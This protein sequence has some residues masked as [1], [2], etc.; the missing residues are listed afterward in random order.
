MNMNIS[1]GVY[2]QELTSPIFYE[3]FI[4]I[5]YDYTVPKLSALDITLRD[6]RGKCTTENFAPSYTCPVFFHYEKYLERFESEMV[7]RAW[8]KNVPNSNKPSIPK[9]GRDF[10]STIQQHFPGSITE[11]F[12]FEEYIKKLQQC[13]NGEVLITRNIKDYTFNI[14]QLFKSMNKNYE[15]EFSNSFLGAQ[16]SKLS[17][18]FYVNAVST[19]QN[20]MLVAYLLEKERWS[21]A[22]LSCNAHLIPNSLVKA[23]NLTDSLTQLKQ[24]LKAENLVGSIDIEETS[25]FYK[26]PITDCSYIENTGNFVVRVQI[27]VTKKGLAPALYKLESVPFIFDDDRGNT[28]VRQLCQIR[29]DPR[30]FIFDKAS[31]ILQASKCNPMMPMC[32]LEHF[33]SSDLVSPCVSAI[34]TGSMEGVKRYC[35][36]ECIPWRDV[37]DGLK[38]LPAFHQ[39]KGD[40]WMVT[41]HPLTGVDI[42]CQ[43]KQ[44]K[45]LEHPEIGALEITVPCGCYLAY[46]TDSYHPESDCKDDIEPIVKH[47]LP[48]H[49]IKD[50]KLAEVQKALSPTNN[51]LN[52]TFSLPEP[53]YVVSTLVGKSF[54]GFGAESSAHVSQQSNEDSS[55]GGGAGLTFFW[56]VF[57]IQSIGFLIMVAIAVF[58]YV[59]RRRKLNA[60]S[61]ERLVYNVYPSASNANLS[62][63]STSSD[64]YPYA[65]Q[66]QR[67]SVTENNLNIM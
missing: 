66:S 67:S 31:G 49:F 53:D 12:G 22:E 54:E 30:T 24:I 27:P 59:D 61:K 33:G 46:H 28:L 44:D 11:Q 38:L 41:G 52:S 45:I 15:N 8:A 42:K 26:I 9:V 13:P 23:S 6:W 19:H 51:D 57:V 48:V 1:L 43:G 37:Q 65:S 56:V 17:P 50:D 16:N 29:A 60:F 18:A 7:P 58:K 2:P 10:C 35:E 55:S 3:S 21:E 39:I 34:F 64:T 62:T 25:A 40:T 5:I 32:K 14:K 63:T 47:I 36:M 20:G 4:P